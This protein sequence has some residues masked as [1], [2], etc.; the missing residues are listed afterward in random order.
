MS[1]AKNHEVKDDKVDELLDRVFGET[2][3]VTARRVEDRRV[4]YLKVLN[5]LLRDTVMVY[6]GPEGE[7]IEVARGKLETPGAPG[8]T[9]V[10]R[11]N[12]WGDDYNFHLD[13]VANI[14][15]YAVWDSDGPIENQGVV[16]NIML[17]E[18]NDIT[19]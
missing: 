2:A 4:T 11:T 15:L 6:R 18:N 9:Y 10:V 12:S 3:E 19:A 16:R 8:Y 1:E 17:V 7:E 5:L 13:E 14:G